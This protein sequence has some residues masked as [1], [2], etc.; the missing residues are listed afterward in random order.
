MVNGHAWAGEVQMGDWQTGSGGKSA[1]V[2]NKLWDADRVQYVK[3]IDFLAN[4]GHV[5]ATCCSFVL[6][7]LTAETV[8]SR[9]LQTHV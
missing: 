1:C 4:V 9:L 5:L 8:T 2:K 7:S 3:V 6:P